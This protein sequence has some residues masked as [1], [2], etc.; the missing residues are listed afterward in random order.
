MLRT[1]SVNVSNTTGTQTSAGRMP[2]QP[3]EFY[4]LCYV[5]CLLPSSALTLLVGQQ[6][7]HPACKTLSGG[8]LPWLSVWSEVQTCI[9]PSWCH[10]LSL[11]LVKSRLVLPLCYRLTQVVPDKGPLNV[12]VCVC[13]LSAAVR[14]RP[15]RTDWRQEERRKKKDPPAAVERVRW[16]D[17]SRTGVLHFKKCGILKHPYRTVRIVF[18]VYTPTQLSIRLIF[19]LCLGPGPSKDRFQNM[20]MAQIPFLLPNLQCQSNGVYSLYIFLYIICYCV[21]SV[22]LYLFINLTSSASTRPR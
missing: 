14:L 11:A 21:V 8:V 20:F 16:K 6:E 18:S 12:C 10:S 2:L 9:W 13:C 3:L 4:F 5:V 7:G 15:R 1:I 19:L 17:V 22:C